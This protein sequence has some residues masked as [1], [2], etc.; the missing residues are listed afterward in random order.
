MRAANGLETP[1]GKLL[2]VALRPHLVFGPGDPHLLPRVIERARAGRLPIVGSGK[3]RVSLTY[4]DNGAHAH[5]AAA[6]S[7]VRSEVAAGRVYFVNQAESVELWPWIFGILDALGV[8]RP[9]RRLSSR[10]AFAAGAAL[11]RVWSVLRL[12][13][14][15]P[16]TRFVAQQLGSTHTYD[17]GP[18]RRDLGYEERVGLAEA[19]ERTIADLTRRFA[20]QRNP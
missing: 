2:T 6:K 1:N 19:T 5:I 14:E 10:A 15:P 18:A 7:L 4:V 11:E 16:M 17:L 12:A 13:G 9:T 8:P 3:N 20:P